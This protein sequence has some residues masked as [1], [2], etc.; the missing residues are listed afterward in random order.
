MLAWADDITLESDA[1]S[2]T[3]FERSVNT[4]SVP[5]GGTLIYAV[6]VGNACTATA[7]NAVISDPI[8]LGL[9]EYAWICG[10][11]RGAACPNA[12]GTGGIAETI[13]TFPPGGGEVVPAPV[14]SKWMLLLTMLAL[15]VA[16]ARARRRSRKPLAKHEGSALR[17]VCG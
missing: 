8:P 4:A 15:R 11:S 7:T 13:A 9:A 2:S 16:G 1:C 10:S 3:G 5:P 12:S 17:G 14:N 6:P